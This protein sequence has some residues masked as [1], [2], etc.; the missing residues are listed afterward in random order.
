MHN[1]LSGPVGRPGTM[2]AADASSGMPSTW[3]SWGH[4]HDAH[5]IF[6]PRRRMPPA[7]GKP[8]IY[9]CIIVR[10]RVYARHGEAGTKLRIDA[11]ACACQVARSRGAALD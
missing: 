9:C 1:I 6:N 3:N 7:I 10:Q 5:H 11:V 2:I 4:C 8:D